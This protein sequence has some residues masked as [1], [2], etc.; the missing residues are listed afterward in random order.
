MISLLSLLFLA[1]LL[2]NP[3]ELAPC[4]STDAPSALSAFQ[5]V[6]GNDIMTAMALVK[7]MDGGMEGS[8]GKCLLEHISAP[9]SVISECLIGALVRRVR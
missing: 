8:C 4:N 6:V 7:H 5:S 2:A 3:A 1:M 9:D